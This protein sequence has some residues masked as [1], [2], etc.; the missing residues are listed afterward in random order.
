MLIAFGNFP[1]DLVSL[2]VNCDDGHVVL[3]RR[4][5]SEDCR[6]PTIAE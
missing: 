5:S 1:R 6:V 4:S 3:V 2:E